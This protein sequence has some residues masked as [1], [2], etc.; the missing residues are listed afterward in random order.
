[1]QLP[2]LTKEREAELLTSP[3][4]E[5]FVLRKYQYWTLYLSDNQSHFGRAYAWLTSR[6]WDLHPL[7]DL[8]PSELAE[9]MH[10]LR[11]YSL[12]VGLVMNYVPELINCEWLGNE[13]HLHRGHGHMH[14][15][16][17]YAKQVSF[18]TY[19]HFDNRFGKRSAYAKFIPPPE[20]LEAMCAQFKLALGVLDE[21]R[22]PF[23]AEE[24]AIAN[25]IG[26]PEAGKGD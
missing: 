1:M 8:T 19:P 7:F 17:R 12:A 3:A 22:E 15:I 11:E 21:G 4:Y 16:P 5:K 13:F 14:F 25:R 2:P 18:A 6:H 26:L 9:L 23:S 20:F 24:R 10:I